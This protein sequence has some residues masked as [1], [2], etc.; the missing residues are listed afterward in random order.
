MELEA[1]RS[2]AAAELSQIDRLLAEKRAVLMREWG[3]AATP[4]TPAPRIGPSKLDAAKAKVAATM[5]KPKDGPTLKDRVVAAMRKGTRYTPEDV[6]KALGV[7]KRPVLDVLK[8]DK[9][10]GLFKRVAKGVYTRK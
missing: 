10:S 4:K 8:A 3:T 5:A 1:A 7:D 2:K 6:A 9:Y